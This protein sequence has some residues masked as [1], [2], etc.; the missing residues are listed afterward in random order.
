MK[1]HIPA[2]RRTLLH[3]GL[4]VFAFSVL[5]AGRVAS[6][7]AAATSPLVCLLTGGTWAD[8]ECV[9]DEP[10]PAPGPAASP[11]P[12][13]TPQPLG[14]AYEQRIT[15]GESGEVELEIDT[16]GSS[17]VR[18]NPKITLQSPPKGPVAFYAA[19]VKD[20]LRYVAT[21]DLDGSI[22]FERFYKGDRFIPYTYGE[23]AGE[24]PWEW[25]CDAFKDF[26]EL[27]ME[28]LRRHKAWFMVAV[29]PK[30]KPEAIQS[31]VFKF[32]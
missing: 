12:E 6:A 10:G 15:I 26:P 1:K 17:T 25:P 18:L 28:V 29:A 19:Y 24:G 9:I 30:G 14:P 21:E 11:T 20:G 7:E 2:A 31:A 22:R 27:D 3:C 4:M 8:G 13:E 23:L 5:L 16:E 32:K